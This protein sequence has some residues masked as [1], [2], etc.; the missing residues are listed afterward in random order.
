MPI[1]PTPPERYDEQ[2]QRQTRR[3][4]E[5]ALDFTGTQAMDTSTGF[6][7]AFDRNIRLRSQRRLR[8][9][10]VGNRHS[11]QSNISRESYFGGSPLHTFYD[12]GSSTATIGVQT[13][14]L[15]TADGP[16]QYIGALVA[17][18]NPDTRY[19]VYVDDPTFA[20]GAVTYLTTT[21]FRDVFGPDRYYV[22]YITTASSTAPSGGDTGGGGGTG[23]PPLIT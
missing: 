4:I 19:H 22:G 8:M 12:S 6:G 16:I 7:V 14:H 9:V 15:E 5:Q 21:E 1:L 18:L 11:A 10:S 13:H 20:G 3:L 2:D 23:E 17:G